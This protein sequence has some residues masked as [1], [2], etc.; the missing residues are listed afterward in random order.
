[1]PAS[2]KTNWLVQI[3]DAT[4]KLVDI[5]Q[6]DILTLQLSDGINGG[7]GA[8]GSDQI[9]FARPYNKIGQI[10]FLYQ[11]LFWMWPAGTVR[12][13]DPYWGGYIVDF[14]QLEEDASGKV[15]AYLFGDFKRL[16]AA[17]VSEQINPGVGINP[18]LDASPYINHLLTT[19]QPTT[20]SAPTLPASM[21]ALNAMQFD[22]TQLGAAVDTI[23]KTGR[24]TSGLFFTWAVRT[25]HDLTRSVVIQ[26]DQNPNVVAGVNFKVLFRGAQIREYKIA[27]K[28]RD[29][30]NVIAVYGGKDPTTGAQAYGVYQDPASVSQF[31]PWQE[32]LSVPTLLSNAACQAYATVFFPLHAYPQAQSAF[33][34]HVPDNAIFGGTWL[35]INEVPKT[36]SQAAVYK[37]V[38]CAMVRISVSGER[39]VQYIETVAPAPYLDVAVYRMGLNVTAAMATII[40]GLP[41]NRQ[42]LYVRAGGNV[43]ST[44]TSPARVALGPTQAVFPGSGSGVLVSAGALPLTV[45]SDGHITTETGIGITTEDGLD[46]AGGPGTDGSFT[47]SLTSAGQYVITKGARPAETA[48][49]LN[50]ASVVVLSVSAPQDTVLVN[51]IRTLIALPT[52]DITAAPTLAAAGGGTISP[53]PQIPGPSNTGAGA[54]DQPITFQ[55]AS[56]WTLANPSLAYLE[57]GWAA[58]GN[59]PTTATKCDPTATGV[60]NG[61]VP[62]IGAGQS[63][64]IYVRAVDTNDRPTPWLG[65]GPTAVNPIG[66]GAVNFG[67]HPV[68]TIPAST[69]LAAGFTDNSVHA[70]VNASATV[71]NCTT[72]KTVTGL[73]FYYAL[74]GSTD[75]NK[76]KPVGEVTILQSG[77]ATQTLQ[78]G[79]EI[80]AGQLI[81]VYVGFVGIGSADYGPLVQIGS[82]GQVASGFTPAAL[83]ITTPYLARNGTAAAPTITAPSYVFTDSANGITG[84]IA[85]TFTIGNQP[86]DGTLKKIAIYRRK[87]SSG[88]MYDKV[89]AIPATGTPTPTASQTYIV[90]AN[91]LTNGVAYDWGVAFED[92]QGGEAPAVPTNGAESRFADAAHGFIVATPAAPVIIGTVALA[93][94]PGGIA[95]AGP[96]LTGTPAVGAQRAGSGV[97]M[98]DVS[99]QVAAS[100]YG[101]SFG[102]VPNWLDKAV[103]IM[104]KAAT[105]EAV[106]IIN[107]LAATTTGAYAG[108]VQIPAGVTVDVGIYYLDQS[109]APSAVVYPSQ[110]A[111]IVGGGIA[112]TA[113]GAMPAALVSAGP[114]VTTGSASTRTI[115]RGVRQTTTLTVTVS[116]FSAQPTWAGD[117]YTVTRIN[118]GATTDAV[119]VKWGSGVTYN[120]GAGTATFVRAVNAFAGDNID[121][122]IYYKDSFGQTS[123]IN[124]A[125]SAQADANGD[126]F[127]SSDGYVGVNYGRMNGGYRGSWNSGGDLT[128]TLHLKL[129]GTLQAAVST[130][131][132]TYTASSGAGATGNSTV[133]IFWDGTNGSSVPTVHYPSQAVGVTTAVTSGNTGALSGLNASTAYYFCMRINM[134]TNA[135]EVRQQAGATASASDH[136]WL[137]LDGYLP[138]AVNM[139][140]NTPAVSSSSGGTP[141]GGGGGGVQ[142]PSS[143]QP[144]LTSRGMIRAGDIVAGDEVRGPDGEWKPVLASSSMPGLLMRARV[145]EGGDAE[146]FDVEETHL[147][148]RPDGSWIETRN[149]TIGTLLQGVDGGLYPVTM[150]E[151]RGPGMFQKL[152]VV[153]A[154]MVMGRV[155][156]HNLITL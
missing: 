57:L 150:L 2:A 83:V 60:Y 125:V 97:A 70:Q 107:P 27:T 13:L 12:P 102:T 145:G 74:H 62:G 154:Q 116:D 77:G 35:Q 40:K 103:L 22:A 151:W 127:D 95:S 9:V 87:T 132:F 134:A 136:Q 5:P 111:G 18:T 94:M 112:N 138:I 48:T 128:T 100:D 38:R 86:T 81:D 1:M 19:Y 101:G 32:K 135:I 141:P 110:W 153:G 37:Q 92:A 41:M 64:T 52:L 59:N 133:T 61:V 126:F 39:V 137:N 63:V 104:R 93:K 65:L 131:G 47:I 122:G 25:K 121:L 78:L 142:C 51:D 119:P 30:K 106:G 53:N 144:M 66:V 148:K 114:T 24:D 50:L 88:A 58:T 130:S 156:G 45:L 76:F 105:H 15:T 90:N 67:S 56:T 31:T 43:T 4:G 113:M 49:Q 29:I 124:W 55:L 28:Y 85:L 71:T 8:G 96:T 108:T 68:P 14:D 75:P 139:Q 46:I 147:W 20:F 36:A 79:F 82:A 146:E 7:S 117:V 84:S 10:G 109:G 143:D 118:G 120:V 42:T 89:F 72:D 80:G 26:S 140:C 155:I 21:F 16:D 115:G 152:R 129:N 123:A 23:T 91:D 34:I 99:C 54:Y 11:V 3:F 98:Q 73:A 17:I 149:C 44:S 6:S 69:P 33:K